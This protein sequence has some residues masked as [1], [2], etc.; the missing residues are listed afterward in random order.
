ME[1]LRT[2]GLDDVVVFGGGIFPEPDI[3]R[4]KEQGVAA[5]FTPGATMEAITSWL[6]ATLDA[7]ETAPAD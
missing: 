4:L 6:A 7:R 5:L 2:R 1:E 3:V